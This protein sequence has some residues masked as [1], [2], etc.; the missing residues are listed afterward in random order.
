VNF[1]AF[2]PD[3]PTVMPVPFG[4]VSNLHRNHFY[5]PGG[6]NWDTVLS[7]T[8]S[9]TERLRFQ[10]RFECYNL[11]NRPTFVQPGNLIADPGLFG[12]STS[13][14]TRPDGTTSNRQLQIGAK[15]LF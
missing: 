8:S 6:N 5:G 7:K 14:F 1:G 13:T 4:T 11:F 12:F 15:L 10:L 9:L 3:D 2:N